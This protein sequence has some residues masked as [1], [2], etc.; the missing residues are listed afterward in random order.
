M[1]QKRT[2]AIILLHTKWTSKLGGHFYIDSF[3]F[4]K[5]ISWFFTVGSFFDTL[6]E[7]VFDFFP[8]LAPF[9]H[10]TNWSKITIKHAASTLWSVYVIFTKI[11]IVASNTNWW[12]TRTASINGRLST[13]VSRE[14]EIDS[15]PDSVWII[16]SVR[17]SV[18]A[19]FLCFC[20]NLNKYVRNGQRSSFK[21]VR[22]SK[23]LKLDENV[24]LRPIQCHRRH[25]VGAIRDQNSWDT[26]LLLWLH[27][28][29]N[30]M[31]RA[32]NQNLPFRYVLGN[33]SIHD[34]NY[35]MKNQ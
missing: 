12:I 17:E 28:H 8:G 29:S 32:E 25:W 30:H 7:I 21:S 9:F 1:I 31:D 23:I 10:Q 35:S 33:F 18:L 22:S 27:L 26:W 4:D 13:S 20:Q 19:E 34:L 15:D 24:P 14:T 2:L 11:W 3:R 6:F 5:N 16:W